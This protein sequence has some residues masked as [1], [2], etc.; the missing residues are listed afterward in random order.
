MN[1]LPESSEVDTS[2]TQETIKEAIRRLRDPRLT[3]AQR[4]RL[5]A[6]VNDAAGTLGVVALVLLTVLPTA[7]MA[8]PSKEIAAQ[9]VRQGYPDCLNRADLN[10]SRPGCE[11]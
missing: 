5:R 8:Q 7:A 2:T 3:P 1:S 6:I 11:G 4:D 9:P 10:G